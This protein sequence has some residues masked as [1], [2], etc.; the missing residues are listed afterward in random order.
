MLK[1]TAVKYVPNAV[2]DVVFRW[3][4]QT[5]FLFN[6]KRFINILW[7]LEVL[8]KRMSIQKFFFELHSVSLIA[9]Q[10]HLLT[11]LRRYQIHLQV[12]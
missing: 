4:K 12:P 3:I 8:L 2:S 5:S 6:L 7:S 11:L 9:N 1:T 10:I